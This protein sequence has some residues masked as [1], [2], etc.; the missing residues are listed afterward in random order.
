MSPSAT[1]GQAGGGAKVRA[2][3]RLRATNVS[4]QR[5]VGNQVL[6]VMVKGLTEFYEWAFELWSAQNTPPDSGNRKFASGQV[7][8]P[9][10][11][12]HQPLQGVGDRIS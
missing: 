7:A 8:V 12:C 4:G 3:H 10:T 11:T 1:D 5:R 2:K 9:V 6:C